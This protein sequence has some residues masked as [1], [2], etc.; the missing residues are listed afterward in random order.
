[1]QALFQYLKLDQHN[2]DEGIDIEQLHNP[3][4]ELVKAILFIYSLDTNIPTV[5]N[6]AERE[7][8]LS[9]VQSLGP[10]A[11]VLRSI[12]CGAQEER[13]DKERTQGI[14][15]VWRGTILH[16]NDIKE[17][18]SKL[19]DK[20]KKSQIRFM[21][22]A[23]ATTTK[24]QALKYIIDDQKVTRST[25]T[26]PSSAN[27]IN[28]QSITD[29]EKDGFHSLVLFKLTLDQDGID[30][31]ELNRPEYSKYWQSE[32][33]VLLQDGMKWTIQKIN[34]T[35]HNESPVVLI[36]LKQT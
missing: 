25:L 18:K 16:K 34:E 36:E 3:T 19:K 9:K 24:E 14:I 35:T 7:K 29:L 28:L 33:A 26:D 13:T 20:L 2:L 6:K 4:S 10:F 12:V 5:L 22:F 27:D 8:D 31:F 15:T 21:G 17:Y 11:L 30:C 32:S 1:M 23:C